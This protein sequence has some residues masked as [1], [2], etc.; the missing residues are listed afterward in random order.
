MGNALNVNN[1]LNMDNHKVIVWDDGVLNLNNASIND[2]KMII[3]NGGEMN[4]SNNGEINLGVNRFFKV[5]EG[6]KMTYA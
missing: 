1:T 3:K 6:G 5:D 4:I 2:T